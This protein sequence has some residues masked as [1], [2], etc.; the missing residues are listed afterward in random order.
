M[1]NMP[2]EGNLLLE[3]LEYISALAPMSPMEIKAPVNSCKTK[4]YLMHISA[5]KFSFFEERAVI[6]RVINSSLSSPYPLVRLFKAR[7]RFL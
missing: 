5:N 4:S 7:N 6:Q 3:V 2:F 1:V